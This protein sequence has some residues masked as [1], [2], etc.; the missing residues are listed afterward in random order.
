MGTRR[1]SSVSIAIVIEMATNLLE[2]ALQIDV[3]PG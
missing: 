3:V 2:L 1:I